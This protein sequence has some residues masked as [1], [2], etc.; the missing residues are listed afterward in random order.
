L[1]RTILLFLFLAS[2]PIA[3]P[4]DLSAFR[5]SVSFTQGNPPYLKGLLF[6]VYYNEWQSIQA[7]IYYMLQGDG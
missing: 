4:S 5:A 3:S 2:F 6:E 1:G 7:K